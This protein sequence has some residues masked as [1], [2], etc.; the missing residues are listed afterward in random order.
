MVVEE[1]GVVGGEG[2][3]RGTEV[4]DRPVT[5]QKSPDIVPVSEKELDIFVT[6]VFGTLWTG[7]ASMRGRRSNESR[8]FHHTVKRVCK[9]AEQNFFQISFP[10]FSESSFV[11]VG[12]LNFRGFHLRMVRKDTTQHA[13]V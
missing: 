7:R 12:V 4:A 2:C 8:F 6:D 10:E 9:A 11:Q 1:T 13:V 3:R 5:A